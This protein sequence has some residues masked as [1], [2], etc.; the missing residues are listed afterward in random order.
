MIGTFG[1]S[2]AANTI[3]RPTYMAY[4]D[5]YA[6]SYLPSPNTKWTI[7]N[8]DHVQIYQICKFHT[9]RN[10]NLCAYGDYCRYIHYEECHRP[11]LAEQNAQHTLQQQ[12]INILG[13]LN[14][15]LT[16][17][18]TAL[19]TQNLSNG[20]VA[21]NNNAPPSNI[22][23]KMDD[24]YVDATDSVVAP[25]ATLD[26]DAIT[27]VD[28][29]ENADDDDAEP[30]EVDEDKDNG[31][32][33]KGRTLGDD[34]CAA[35]TGANDTLPTK[36]NQAKPIDNDAKI[37]TES[38]GY[39]GV[40]PGDAKQCAKQLSRHEIDLFM[41]LWANSKR[42]LLQVLP[43]KVLP[44]S[45]PKQLLC[46][47]DETGLPYENA[48]LQG[49]KTKKYNGVPVRII[50][51]VA[52]RNRY[53]VD[54]MVLEGDQIPQFSVKPENLNL[55]EPTGIGDA[56]KDFKQYLEKTHDTTLLSKLR[57]DSRDD[58]LIGAFLDFQLPPVSNRDEQIKFC[59]GWSDI[60]YFMLTGCGRFQ[61]AIDEQGCQQIIA[62]LYHVCF[63]RGFCFVWKKYI[64]PIQWTWKKWS[65]FFG[66]MSYSLSPPH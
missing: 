18:L 40:S 6:S 44:A 26:D 30:V 21:G 2:T 51:Y 50:E 1:Y 12:V 24:D 39:E 46:S 47:E 5:P 54:V 25:K 29:A 42:H 59:H 33:A 9:S 3:A 61:L 14:L 41:Y 4:I 55:L 49:L 7:R 66:D 36:A 34:Q 65:G 15:V 19:N 11:S 28:V 10:A 52:K 8:K 64:I 60:M 38:D 32:D 53:A 35:E 13:Q 43:S 63:L 45:Y 31:N 57:T 58:A 56:Y 23:R 37:D 62:L 27:A 16:A 48:T 20:L 22:E 17:I